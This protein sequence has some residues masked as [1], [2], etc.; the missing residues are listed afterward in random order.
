MKKLSICFIGRALAI[1]TICCGLL[2]STFA[3]GPS[4]GP[5][6]NDKEENVIACPVCLEPYTKDTIAIQLDCKQQ[7]VHHICLECIN[8]LPANMR[9]CPLCRENLVIHDPRI[10]KSYTQIHHRVEPLETD[11]AEKL[12]KCIDFTIHST[13]PTP[14]SPMRVCAAC[15]VEA[16]PKE[17][18]IQ[19][20]SGSCC[21]NHALDYAKKEKRATSK[22]PIMIDPVKL[23]D[24]G[25]IRFVY[26]QRSP[27][28][29]ELAL[30]EK[31]R[32][33]T[34]VEIRQNHIP[35]TLRIPLTN[36]TQAPKPAPKPVKRAS[37]AQVAPVT[38]I[39]P[40]P[41]EYLATLSDAERTLN[42]GPKYDLPIAQE[43]F[44]L[45]GITDEDMRLNRH[46]PSHLSPLEWQVVIRQTGDYKTGPIVLERARRVHKLEQLPSEEIAAPTLFQGYRGGMLAGLW[47]GLLAGQE[48][49]MAEKAEPHELWGRRALYGPAALATY[50][51][52]KHANSTKKCTKEQ[53]IGT[54]VGFAGG[55]LL[56]YLLNK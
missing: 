44:P 21:L 43:P 11:Q 31:L 49:P 16:D 25:G 15:K 17:V 22:L 47:L 52:L 27:T 7:V 10:E 55:M 12:K 46:L 8:S 2:E 38:P 50:S 45:E 9:Q 51:L 37:A 5:N 40:I 54:G 3:M 28:A 42:T 24:K 6:Q 35:E 36:N 23:D 39:M 34:V 48:L 29:S 26:K 30:I 18:V 41:Q 33:S 14:D 19:F 53:L 56:H 32:S 4:K 1:L 13:K 20:A